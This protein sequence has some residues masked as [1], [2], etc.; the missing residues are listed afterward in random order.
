MYCLRKSF[1]NTRPLGSSGYAQYCPK[2]LVLICNRRCMPTY[3][4]ITVIEWI[5]VL[6]RPVYKHLMVDSLN[7]CIQHKGLKVYC[8][9][10]MSNHLHL[11]AIAEE[12][13]LSDILRDFKKFTSKA[14]IKVIQEV[15]KSRTFATCY[16]TDEKY[17]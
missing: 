8:W 6:S 9:C 12:G 4:T 5:N 2:L 15:N 16:I 1:I 13:S 11:V 14:L 7:Y 10:L 3:L 17:Y